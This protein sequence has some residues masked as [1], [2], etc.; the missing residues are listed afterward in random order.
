MAALRL[1]HVDDEPDIREIVQISLSLDPEMETRSCGSGQEA[2]D[3]I[4]IW[5]PDVIL[6]DVMMPIMDGPTTF[7]R[8]RE[9]PQTANIPVIFMTARA[10]PRELDRL[11]AMGAVDVIPKPFDPMGLAARLRGC[12]TTVD[13]LAALRSSFML[14][15]DNDAV[16]L[17]RLEALLATDTL[18]QPA[19]A[20]IG[21]IA[22]RLAGAGGIFGF[23]ELSEAASV[24]EETILAGNSNAP[25]VE[26]SN[27][28]R[29]LIVTVEGKQ[30]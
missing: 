16:E 1:L 26:V 22:H 6:L 7:A 9:N 3:V 21:S 28:I 11:L 2:L 29:R 4:R 27:A 23:A 8:V 14:R 17:S 10:Q 30:Q 19:L 20:E 5:T 13:P 15:A 12:V 18:P 25:L 24:L